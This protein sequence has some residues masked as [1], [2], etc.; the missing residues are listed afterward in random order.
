MRKG[1]EY[2]TS[3]LVTEQVNNY[4]NHMQKPSHKIYRTNKKYVRRKVRKVLPQL[5]TKFNN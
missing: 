2:N 3:E 5:Q 4:S 1:E